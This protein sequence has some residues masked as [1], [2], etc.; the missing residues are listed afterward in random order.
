M[1]RLEKCAH[2]LRVRPHQS[3]ADLQQSGGKRIIDGY[4]GDYR[5]GLLR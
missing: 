2:N 1:I 3:R 4:G 5:S